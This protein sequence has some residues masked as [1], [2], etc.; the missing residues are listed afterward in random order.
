MIKN[1]FLPFI[2]ICLAFS[3]SFGQGFET[4][5]NLN[6]PTG[7]YG[8]GS[9]TGDNG[10]TWT[11]D[12]ARTVNAGDNITGRSIGFGDSSQ[13]T[14]NITA[15]TDANGVGDLT[16]SIT[17][18]FTGGTAADR[19]I[20]VYVNGTLYDSYTLAA[21]G[22]DYTRTLTANETG[23]VLIEFRSV[24][25][26]QIVIDDVSWTLPSTD[27][28]V[29]FLSSTS[30]LAEDGLFMDVCVGITNASTTSATT[31]D[32]E[33]DAS[34]IATNGSD[35]DNGA[36]TPAAITFPQTL[37]FPAN[38][39]ADQC[40]TIF[41]SND[42]VLVEGDETVV[43]NLTNPT[44]GDSASLGTNTQ[45]T[46]TITDNDV[47]AIADVVITEIMYNTPSTDDEWIEICN[48]SGSPQILND[49]TIEVGGSTEFT[50]PSSGVIIADGACITVSLGSNGD[51]T[52]NNDCPFTPDYGVGASTNNTNNL[53]NNSSSV[54]L[55]ASDG[56]TIID[57]VLYDDN[58][59]SLTDGNGSSF[60]V[61]DASLDNSD[62]DT[63][64]Q[65]VVDGGSPGTNS[66]VSACSALEPE[67][68]IEGDIGAFPDIS[69]GDITP[70]FLD[71][72]EFSSQIISVGSQTKS[73]IIENLGLVDLSVS[74]IEIIGADAA[75]FTVTL[76]SAL[77]L[78]ITSNTEV[79]FD[80]T[81]APLSAAGIRNATV[82]ITNNDSA[83]GEGEEIYEFAIR[84]EA[85]CDAASNIVSPLT[86]PVNTVVTISGTDLDGS[87]SVTYDGVTVTHT[88]ISATEIE[89]SI[90]NG[91]LSG[92]IEVTNNINCQSAHAFT[93][94]DNTISSCEGNGG[95]TPTDL[96]ISEIT[97][98]GTGSHSYIELYN[99]TGATVDLTDYEIRIHNN[100]D[101]TTSN[102]ADLT[103]SMPNNTTYVIAVGGTNASDPEGGYTAD[104]FY[105]FGGINDNDNIRLYFNDG[106]NPE[107]W[108]DLWGDTSGAT[109]TISTN[110]YN[111]RRKNTGISVPSTTWD[112]NDWDILT[113]LDYSNIGVFDFSTGVPPTVTLQPV[114]TAFDCTFSASYTI[115]GTEGY[116]GTS[117]A[118]TKELAYQWYYNAPGSVTWT[119]ILASDADYA[120]QQ[121]ATLTI[122]DTSNFNGYQYYCQLR[123][124]SATCFEASNA[125]KLEAL[126]SIWDG[127]SWSTPPSIDRAIII[128][129]DYDT[130]NGT[131]GQTSFSGCS[132]IVNTGY[133]LQVSNNTYIEIENDIV[134]D[135]DITVFTAGAVVQNNDL[136]TVTANGTITVQK[137]TSMISTPYQ[138][139]YWSSPVV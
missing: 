113:P 64:W 72:T 53:G 37:T 66:L 11:Y 56:S 54:T 24:G 127:S 84:G 23:A 130:S 99:G 28:L 6:A 125:V 76:P 73:F 79:T 26:R 20:E 42:D 81:F 7:G 61:I 89:F 70:S 34:S 3:F 58:D 75:D 106:I 121:S 55:K 22:P 41:I 46:L 4:F 60:H 139:T 135:G 122:T 19:S 33:L 108:V 31:V 36:G 49:Y 119:E 16:Y 83:D 67:I 88:F 114:S 109:F 51:G 112:S 32:I 21:E 71:N 110:D 117:P 48:T 2:F 85:I 138:Y 27:T 5:T 52:Y 9:Y 62:T 44:G 38:D 50:F 92:N 18:Y 128:D 91:A 94:I 17:S 15:T 133:T 57:D 132:L 120:G 43:L 104:E 65:A 80:V 98:K 123:E 59:E 107:T 96:F 10:I 40:F 136:A 69:N 126:S 87:T 97:D 131:G 35:Y 78:I 100:G 1:Y 86:G 45:H 90:P 8:N 115:T 47:A 137:E 13:G 93:L 68:N 103:G 63:N 82:R 124:D 101:A 129:G 102:I 30:T 25:S 74:N 14:R 118:D 39:S 95:V 111:Y 105:G 12:G 77:P 29:E 134:A 116:N